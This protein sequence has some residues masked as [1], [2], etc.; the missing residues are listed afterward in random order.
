MDFKLK[1]NPS[2]LILDSENEFVI[3]HFLKLFD[4]QDSDLAKKLLS[5]LLKT[6]LSDGSFPSEYDSNFG[7]IKNTC[8]ITHLLLDYDFLQSDQ[9]ISSAIDFLLSKQNQDGGWCENPEIKIPEEVIELSTENSITWLTADVVDLIHRVGKEETDAYNNALSWIIDIQ[10]HEGGWTMWRKEKYGS[11][12]DS[13]AQILFM[14][15]DYCSV[16]YFSWQ[17]GLALYERFL[18]EREE[19]AKQ[20]YYIE[21]LTHKKKKNDIY[22]LSH[23]L[24]S[25]LTDKDRRIKFGYNMNDLRVRT[26][27][28]E[29]INIQNQDGGWNPFWQKE[30]DPTYTVLALKLLVLL[31]LVAKEEIRNYIQT[32]IE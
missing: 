10:N 11:D 27:V 1:K 4:L 23:L 13:T 22:T 17:K 32:I 18:N 12:S 31:E 15:K 7:S 25:S 14:L 24:L 2:N 6:Q 30:S 21:P 20:G 8:R 26:I 29:I 16:E 19:E 9:V 28:E 3:L 5:N